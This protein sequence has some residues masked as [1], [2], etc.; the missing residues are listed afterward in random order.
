MQSVASQTLWIFTTKFLSINDDL[1]TAQGFNYISAAAV[2][3]CP[4]LAGTDR[5][6][7]AQYGIAARYSIGKF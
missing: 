1:I 5:L 3:A 6:D 4:Q 7:N 2:E